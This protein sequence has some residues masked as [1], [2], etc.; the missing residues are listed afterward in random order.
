MRRATFVIGQT[1]DGEPVGADERVTLELGLDDETLHIHV[2]APFHGD[3]PPPGPPGATERLWQH[4]VA[5]VFL[6]G[7]DERY[8]EIELGPFGHHLVLQLEG[9]RRATARGLSLDY[10]VERERGRWRG[11]ARAPRAWLPAGLHA[12]NAF[13]VHGRGVARRHLVAR[14][15]GGDAPDFHRIAGFPALVWR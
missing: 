4:E 8:L 11:R 15:L 2:D 9:V 3:P 1:W 10:E 12:A 14:P 13:S 7:R 6:V 5:E